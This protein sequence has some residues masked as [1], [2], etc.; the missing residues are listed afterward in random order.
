MTEAG[1]NEFPE[2]VDFLHRT[3]SLDD[4]CETETDSRIASMGEKAPDCFEEIGTV[5][6]ILDR[7]GSCFWKCS[8]G[9]HTIEYLCGRVSSNGRATVRLLRMGFYDESLLLSRSIGEIA[10]V[11][12]LFC[13]DGT[14]LAEWRESWEMARKNF[15]PA[16]VS[17]R[18]EG[19][20]KLPPPIDR[21]RYYS[22]SARSAHPSPDLEPQS[23]NLLGVPSTGSR[24]Q[25]I[26]FLV[27]LNELALP[28]AY[29]SLAAVLLL[30]LDDT[31]KERITS[32]AENA[33]KQIGSVDLSGFK[34]IYGIAT[35]DPRVRDE[36]RRR[37]QELM[38]LQIEM[39]EFWQARTT[40][41]QPLGQWLVENMPRGANLEIPS[42]RES[43]REIPFH[44]GES[45]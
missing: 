29:S 30:D 45:R 16:E 2:G 23:F 11:L 21:E 10:N 43:R 40:P 4:R 17:R 28:L 18:L 19:L 12:V 41:R 14:A 20:T 27:C 26:G 6:S 25:E 37:G 44:D 35:D 9:D 39:Q 1:A 24:F 8:G 33:L 32:A 34:E 15:A 38:Q 3:W 31:V 22:L 5:L 36:L 7:M 13:K 42:R